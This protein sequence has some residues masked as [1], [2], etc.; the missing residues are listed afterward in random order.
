MHYLRNFQVIAILLNFTL[1]EIYSFRTDANSGLII[2]KSF[3]NKSVHVTANR[4]TGYISHKI[5]RWDEKANKHAMVDFPDIVKIYNPAMGGV[6][7]A[8]MLISL[9]CTP[10]KMGRWYLWLVVHSLGICKVSAWLLYRRY[11]PSQKYQL[12]IKVANALIYRA[13]PSGRP[14]GAEHAR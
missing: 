14:V 7:L 11:E 10:Y 8:G 2:M 4:G 1:S 5:Q 13:K 6:D 3:D 12:V 9:Y